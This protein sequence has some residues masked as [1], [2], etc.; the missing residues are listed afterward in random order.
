MRFL[1]LASYALMIR[2][3]ADS[4]TVSV[5]AGVRK[6]PQP[7]ISGL[8]TNLDRFN[9]FSFIYFSDTDIYFSNTSE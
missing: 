4:Y 2:Y 1:V 3:S 8:G 9:S 7:S 6:F 5:M